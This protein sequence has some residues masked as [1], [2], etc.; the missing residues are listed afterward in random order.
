M[1]SKPLTCH[2]CGSPDL[3]LRESRLETA[4]WQEGLLL[5]DDGKIVALG[6]GTFYPGELQPGKTEIECDGCGHV[7]R[8]RREFR[9]AEG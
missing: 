5:T 3:T 2:H 1:A 8:P 6:E 7:W 9:G 4:E